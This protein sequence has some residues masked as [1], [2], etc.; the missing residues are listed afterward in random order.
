MK[1]VVNSEGT[2]IYVRPKGYDSW[3]D[4]WEKH[5]G[6]KAKSCHHFKT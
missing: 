6:K 5:T 2:S 3:L 4:Y 1:K